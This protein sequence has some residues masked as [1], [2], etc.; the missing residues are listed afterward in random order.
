[1]HIERPDDAELPLAVVERLHSV[2]PID[3]YRLLAIVPQAVIPWTD[4]INALY[5][6][7]LDPRLR[8]IAICRQ[9][10]TARA[11]YELFQHRQIARNNGVSDAELAAVLAEPVVTSLDDVANLVCQVADELE[12]TATL[13]DET[14]ESVYAAL[15]RRQATELVLILSVYCAVARFTN[16][17]RAAIEPDN[18]LA[19]A[20]NPNVG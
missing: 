9:A 12:T 13:S 10:R 1:M 7:E 2:P 5:D 20:S 8:E 4:L 15:G 16:G 11:Q 3:I 14:Q 17:T 19:K 6:C 18:P